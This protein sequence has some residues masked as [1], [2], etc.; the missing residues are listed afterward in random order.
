M[1]LPDCPRKIVNNW[2]P[3]SSS[4][5]I[6]RSA[7]FDFG[8]IFEQVA[9]SVRIFGVHLLLFNSQRVESNGL[10]FH[11]ARFLTASDLAIVVTQRVG[12]RLVAGPSPQCA[13]QK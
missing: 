10:T 11:A 6:S 1:T 9:Q 3:R 4:S 5:V 13:P 7:Q 2:S 12:L 8:D